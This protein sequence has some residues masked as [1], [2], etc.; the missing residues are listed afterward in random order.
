MKKILFLTLITIILLTSCTQIA[1]NEQSQE[2]DSLMQSI[3][4]DPVKD[5]CI[6]DSNNCQEFPCRN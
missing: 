2:I 6:V 3:I 1:N 5:S 4:I